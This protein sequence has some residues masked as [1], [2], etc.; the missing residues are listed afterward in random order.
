MFTNE[1]DSDGHPIC[2][3]CDKAVMPNDTLPEDSP[4]RGTGALT[5]TGDITIIHKHCAK[6]MG[7]I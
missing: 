5:T 2:M 6:E 7:L 4:D 3:L 1:I